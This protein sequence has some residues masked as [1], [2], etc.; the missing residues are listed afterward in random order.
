VPNAADT[1]RFWPID[2]A[3]RQAWR[4]A[5]GIDAGDLVAIFAGG[6]WA[7]KGLDLALRGVA[8]LVSEDPGSRLKLF[9]AGDDPN[10]AS[11]DQLVGDLGIGTRV[12]FGG[13]RKDIPVALAASDFFLFPSR[14][15]AFSLATIEAAACGLPIV[16]SKINGTEDF[17]LPG[18]TGAFVEHDPGH[19][20]ATLQ[21]L[22]AN[23]ERV[24]QMGQAGRA[25]SGSGTAPGI[26]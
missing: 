2:E 15:Q 11:F 21:T 8:K 19:I 13:F 4:A 1:Q 18:E 20:A 3:A 24:R 6:E 7:R 22:V 17:I 14:T 23:P 12:I 25:R 5:N 9:V 10:R 16:A 26:G